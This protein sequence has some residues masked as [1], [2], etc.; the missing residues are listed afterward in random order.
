MADIPW[1]QR[2]FRDNDQVEAVTVHR[3]LVTRRGLLRAAGFAAPAILLSHSA[4]AQFTGCLPAFC[5]RPSFTPAISGIVGMWDASNFPSLTLSGAD[6]LS[7]ADGSGGGNTMTP[8]GSG[9]KP[10]YNATG[11]NSRPAMV[12]TATD[13]GAFEAASFPIGTGNTLTVWYV[14][15]L[16]NNAS[17]PFGRFMSYT[18][19]AA[20]A[21]FNNVGSFGM[22]TNSGSQTLVQVANNSVFV[23]NSGLAAPP[24]GHRIIVT[25]DS[26]GVI[27][28]YVD[29]VAGT[30][31]TSVGNWVSAGFA[32]IG[33]Q[34][35][36][37]ASGV[38]FISAAV[39][40]CGIATSF[41]NSAAVAAI[42]V[43]LKNKWGL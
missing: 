14:G 21:D 30:P 43:G 9:H 29:G 3:G 4:P 36:S 31:A 35:A 16:A 18:K 40:E 25:K 42:D 8:A 22:T 41:N 27:T 28:I 2:N 11:F 6:I 13:L 19:P 15:T 39:G 17:Q 37:I 32:N 10:Q 38:D 34:H 20:A 23:T 12:F 7:V 24:A 5:S 33:M 1:R 26:S